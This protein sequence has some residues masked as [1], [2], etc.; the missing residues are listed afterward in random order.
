MSRRFV[1]AGLFVAALVL[2]ADEARPQNTGVVQLV[3]PGW[4]AGKL[5][6]LP[7]EAVGR[8]GGDPAIEREYG[9]GFL[10]HQ[11]FTEAQGSADVVAEHATDASS[12]YGLF[13]FYRT[14]DMA[15]EPDMR[16][17]SSGKRGALLFRGQL[18][19][20]VVLAPSAAQTITPANLRALLAA[21][22]AGSPLTED[23]NALPAPL[24][25]AGLSAGSEKYLLGPESARRFLPAVPAE[26]LGFNLG[27]EVKTGKYSAGTSEATVAVI[28]YP[29]PQI[30]RSIY[31][32]MQK[33]LSLNQAG[34]AIGKQEGSFVVLVFNASSPA[35][36][37]RLMEQFNRRVALTWDKPYQGGKPPLIEML[38]FIV[39]NLFFVFYL[40][41]W[42]V[43]GGLIIYLSRQAAR[44]WFPQT[45]FG[46]A[47]DQQ[48]IT[49]K[50]S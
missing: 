2:A 17:V 47:D 35:A 21:L 29:T 4:R 30:A 48:F 19:I 41:G 37:S 36:A 14:A 1:A 34:S 45:S 46:Q 12:T 31:E 13:T 10:E 5:E 6:R 7:L 38:N 23:M 32:P 27:A 28:T 40:C 25:S 44:R 15:D 39:Q 49:L 16:Y 50:L 42:S 3:S 22:G 26:L 24:P 11:V 8:W 33:R 20:R 18:F 43:I 9:V